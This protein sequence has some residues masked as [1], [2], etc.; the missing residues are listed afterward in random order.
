MTLVEKHRPD[1]NTIVGLE[2]IKK[3]LKRMINNNTTQ[4][5]I[6]DGPPGCGKT[7][8]A[9]AFA[10][11]Y[12]GHDIGFYSNE[13]DFDILN[14][15]D[16]RG[17]DTVR[18]FLKNYCYSLSSTMKEDKRL[19][20]I[21]VLDEFDNTTKDFQRAFRAVL[22]GC[23]DYC[24]VIMIV[25][26]I[27]GIRERA[28][29]SRATYFPFEP[30]EPEKLE[31][32]F[33]G[34]AKKEGIEFSND[35]IIKDIISH[36]EYHGDFRRIINDTLQKLVGI[37]RPVTKADLPWIY[38][39]SYKEMINNMIKTGNFV[40]QYFSYEG[41]INASVFLRELVQRIGKKNYEL[42][43]IIGTCEYRIK[44]GGDPLVQ[45]MTVLTACESL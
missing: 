39:D 14:A 40:N 12:F 29:L 24:I 30:Q 45:M 16:H 3:V 4:H 33:L 26:H 9:F 32:Y 28:I 25:N 7:T 37:Q 10:K 18:G 23:Q 34:I 36:P 44:T 6:F 42:A 21:L 35:D 1:F 15:S 41:N 13:E 27:E 8:M 20:R 43:K 31:E 2:W 38:R 17:I 5:M 19:K 22:E 11:E